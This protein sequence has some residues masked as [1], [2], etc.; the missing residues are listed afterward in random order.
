MAE[1]EEELIGDDLDYEYDLDEEEEEALLAGEVPSHEVNVEDII[2]LGVED[3][4]GGEEDG[5]HSHSKGIH[6]RLQH[7]NRLQTSGRLQH[8]NARYGEDEPTQNR[9]Q[10]SGRLQPQNDI[11]EEEMQPQNRLQ[12][13]GRMQSA[14]AVYEEEEE[15]DIQD[16][17]DASMN[18]EP[19]AVH[20]QD[21]TQ[22]VLEEEEDDDDEDEGGGR[23]RFK[24]ERSKIS[25][26]NTAA[27]RVI[28]DSLDQ[29]Q[30]KEQLNQQRG[31]GGRGRGR[32]GFIPRGGMR[33]GQRGGRGGQMS[34]PFGFPGGRGM[35][36]PQ[37]WSPKSQQP[38]PLMMNP[39]NRMNMPG[40]RGGLPGMG[41]PN[42]YSLFGPGPPTNQGQNQILRNA[43]PGNFSLMGNVP[44][45]TGV[46]PF[47]APGILSQLIP[48]PQIPPPEDMRNLIKKRGINDPMM[49]APNKQMKVNQGPINNQHM[50][51]NQN[52]VPIQH[53]NQHMAQQRGG[54]ARK[55]PVTA[56]LSMPAPNANPN[57]TT[58]QTAAPNVNPNLTTIKTV[59]INAVQRQN[60]QNKPQQNMTSKPPQNINQTPQQAN[61]LPQN[62]SQPKPVQNNQPQ[63][64]HTSNQQNQTSTVQDQNSQSKPPSEVKKGPSTP[65]D[66]EYQ[67]KLEQQKKLR[68][69]MLAKKEARR[70]A[71]ATEMAK[72]KAEDDN[73]PVPPT[74]TAATDANKPCQQ[75]QQQPAPT[76]QP[77]PVK[78]DI[79]GINKV[80]QHQQNVQQNQPSNP[81]ISGRPLNQPN[82]PQQNQQ[83]QQGFRKMRMPN[84]PNPGIPRPHIN[85]SQPFRGGMNQHQVRGPPPSRFNDM[86]RPQQNNEQKYGQQGR[87]YYPPSQNVTT[88]HQGAP[89]QQHNLQSPHHLPSG[90]P[91]PPHGPP[92]HGPSHGPPPHGFVS[93][94]PPHSHEHHAPPPSD[95]H[96][97]PLVS[98]MPRAT[99]SILSAPRPSAQA[100]LGPPPELPHRPLIDH[101]DPYP[102]QPDIYSSRAP[103]PGRHPHE[104]ERNYDYNNQ[105]YSDSQRSS[106]SWNEYSQSYDSYRE[107]YNERDNYYL[108]DSYQGQQ[109]YQDNYKYDN[110]REYDN[111]NRDDYYRGTYAY[112]QYREGDYRYPPDSVSQSS[113]SMPPAKQP[114]GSHMD[115]DRSSHNVQVQLIDTLPEKPI[116]PVVHGQVVQKIQT[117]QRQPVTSMRKTLY[118]R[119]TRKNAKGEV[120]SVKKI[121]VDESGEQI[122]EPITEYLKTDVIENPQTIPVVSHQQVQERVPMVKTVRQIVRKVPVPQVN[123]EVHQANQLRILRHKKR[124]QQLQQ[125]QQ[126][127]KVVKRTV[128]TP[129]DF[130]SLHP[131]PVTRRVIQTAIS[132]PGTSEDMIQP[133]SGIR[134]VVAGSK[135]LTESDLPTVQ[136]SDLPTNLT[137]GDVNQMVANAGVGQPMSVSYVPGSGECYVSFRSAEIAAKFYHKMNRRMVNMSF[138]KANMLC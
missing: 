130:V 131:K 28:P 137:L 78:K 8:A 93:H 19:V 75:Q 2:E 115:M 33:G 47:N 65:E 123:A 10:A 27:K 24:S 67:K 92:P 36:M 48:R 124:Q 54:M 17:Y 82:L 89:L 50:P 108:R 127:I 60:L 57:L 132:Q 122:G 37:P 96:R 31:P 58:I 15:E 22:N 129:G 6:S 106:S 46:G 59:D 23:D 112:D 38:P 35:P 84:P 85:Q 118:R 74:T 11:Y 25:L 104:I 4:F 61:R 55:P 113:R 109:G 29:V 103:L 3:D 30:V 126:S 56:R 83:R 100:I 99:Q 34:H 77:Q 66:L 52:M 21:E 116:I 136:L 134:R 87:P 76:P 42:I 86:S 91:Q 105:Q 70:K 53:I 20:I 9:L 16:S 5:G 32:G 72:K 68:E 69:E 90:G 14:D 49:G 43:N 95:M 26:T 1:L 64:N 107:G 97:L 138:I 102:S 94:G 63:P 135:S 79:P 114:V 80:Q 41:R 117:V 18:D 125:A 120:I 101:H 98:Q 40:G 73:K 45:S 39:P 13:S 111:R 51:P 121:P 62:Q 133:G 12:A 128:I 88:H 44:W 81:L 110:Y 7:P 71:A 119:I